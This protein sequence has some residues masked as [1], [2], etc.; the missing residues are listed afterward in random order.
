MT[1]FQIIHRKTG[2][3]SNPAVRWGSLTRATQHDL[4]QARTDLLR[5]QIACRWSCVDAMDRRSLTQQQSRICPLCETESQLTELK[6]YQTHCIFGG[7]TVRRYQCPACDLIYGPDKMFELTDAELSQ[8]YESHYQA[9]A[10]GDSTESELRAFHALQPK[11]DGLYL[12]FGSGSWS[13]SLQVL[14]ADGWQ[15]FGYEPH[16]SAAGD[17]NDWQLNRAAINAMH[18][19]GIF[20][21]NVLEHFRDPVAELQ[22][23]AAWLQPEGRMAHATPCYEYCYEYT[24]FHLFFFPGKSRDLLVQKAGLKPLEYIVDGDFRCSVLQPVP[25]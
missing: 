9:Y 21:N 5:S 19:D 4:R 7:G 22:A 15:V 1:G 25:G 14:R 24:R 12:N 23:M 16:A 18:F 13:R 3:S 10:E 20:S 11:R 6:A 8:D 17:T 2:Q